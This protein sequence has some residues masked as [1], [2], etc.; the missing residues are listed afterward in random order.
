[1]K[2]DL[3]ALNNYLF[4]CIER[5]MDDSLTDEQLEREISRSESVQKA[6]KTIIDTNALVLQAKK[7]FDEYGIQNNITMPMLESGR[8]DYDIQ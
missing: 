2:N 5:V 4:E 7:H 3:V 8:N 6:A 1:M